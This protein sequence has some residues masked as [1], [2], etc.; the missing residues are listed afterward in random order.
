MS[1]QIAKGRRG[2]AADTSHTLLGQGAEVVETTV[3]A[4]RG[5]LIRNGGAEIRL[6]PVGGQ[7]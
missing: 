6:V 1:R 5:L 4:G 7:R 3:G 2:G